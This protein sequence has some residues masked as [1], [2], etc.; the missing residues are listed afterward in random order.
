MRWNKLKKNLEKEGFEINTKEYG[1][2]EVVSKDI[3]FETTQKLEEGSNYD[4]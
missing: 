2:L 4:K 3:V 1:I